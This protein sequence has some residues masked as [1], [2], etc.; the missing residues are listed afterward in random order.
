MK[1]LLVL[2]ATHATEPRTGVVLLPPGATELPPPVATFEHLPDGSVHAALLGSTV[3]V[4]AD[5]APGEFGAQLLRIDSGREAVLCDR[6]MHATRPLVAWGR[7]FVERG[8]D[9]E[10]TID[11]I[12]PKTGRARVV[13]R[14]AGLE[15]FLAG[16]S[17]SE[18]IVYHAHDRGAS[19]LAVT[20]NGAVRTILPSLPPFARD[21]TVDET[22]VVFQNRDEQRRDLWVIDRVELTTGARTRLLTSSN[23]ALAP[24]MWGGELWYS[25]EGGDEVRAISPDGRVAAQLHHPPGAP[26]PE[27]RL[28]DKSGKVRQIAAPWP[29]HFDV[30]GFQ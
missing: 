12:D 3:L 25:R 17:A 10:L 8:R 30:A 2:L 23:Q 6:V 24:K 1:W 27:L 29:T 16:A 15:A 11:E 22:S 18:I 4:V 19:L 20:P 13:W 21:F 5:R 28:V 26:I 14:G 7:V 9:G